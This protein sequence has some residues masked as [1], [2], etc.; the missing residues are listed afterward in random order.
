MYAIGN[1]H[2]GVAL[3]E[4]IKK[5]IEEKGVEVK[6]FGTQS[7]EASNYPEIAEAVA[8]AVASGECERGILICGT[9]VGISI[10]ANKVKGIRAVCCSEPFSAKLSKQHNNSNILCFGARVVGTELA[11]MIVESWMD[12]EF[13]GGRHQ[14][15]IDMIRDI[16]NRQK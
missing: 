1:D 3:K 9:G 10:A 12:A 13:Q 14:V 7:T 5:F 16:E 4:I 2:T 6:D 11:K 15:R 8:N